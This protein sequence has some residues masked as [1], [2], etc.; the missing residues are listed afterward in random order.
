M[1]RAAVLLSVVLLAGLPVMADPAEDAFAAGRFMEAASLAEAEGGADNLARAARCVL[2]EEVTGGSLDRSALE[3]AERLSRAALSQDPGHVEGRLQLAI[4]LSLKSRLMST[5]DVL[6]AGYGSEGRDLVRAV[7]EDEPANSY[8]HGFLAVWNIEV[9]RKG[10]A[11]G[12]A[13]FGAGLDQARTHFEAALASDPQ[14]PA[15]CWQYARAL[16]AEDYRKH[17][18]EVFEALSCALE[19]KAETEL[20]RVMQQRAREF[21]AYARGHTR[22]EIEARAGDLL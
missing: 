1:R 8:A 11:L 13:W 19:T 3:R 16:A 17:H 6:K 15:L 9:V 20:D 18:G 21:W 4:A 10:G 7:L 22:R 5:S 12:A 14:N 2:A